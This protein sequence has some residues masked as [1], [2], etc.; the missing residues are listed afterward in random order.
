[1]PDLRSHAHRIFGETMRKVALS[2]LD[3]KRYILEDGVHTLAFGHQ[4]IPS[5]DSESVAGDLVTFLNT[6]ALPHLE[7]NFD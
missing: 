3:T 2:P 1:M 6:T 4:D 7:L 5:H